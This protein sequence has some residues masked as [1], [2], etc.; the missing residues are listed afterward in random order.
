MVE[1]RQRRNPTLDL[2]LTEGQID[3]H[4]V[5]VDQRWKID[6]V[7][8]TLRISPASSWPVELTVAGAVQTAAGPEKFKLT[9][10]AD[11]A[12]SRFC[13]KQYCS[14]QR[15]SRQCHCE[16]RH[17]QWWRCQWQRCE[18]SRYQG[19]RRD[20]REQADVAGAKGRVASRSA[21]FGDVPVVVGPCR[22]RG[23]VGGPAF[24]EIAIPARHGRRGQSFGRQYSSRRFHADRDAVGLRS[25]PLR[26]TEHALQTELETQPVG[27]GAIGC[28]LRRG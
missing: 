28:H 1:R 8:T 26:K 14:G 11:G 6:S 23:P 3:L 7:S 27:C 20:D 2:E 17:C 9:Y 22:A 24:R 4:D 18:R 25:G 19:R 21:S 15:C 13:T 10:L 16:R 5:A 12:V